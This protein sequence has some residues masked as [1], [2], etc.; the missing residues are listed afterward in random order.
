MASVRDLRNR[1]K[2]IRQTLQI[3]SAM[4]LISTSK[5]RR[6]RKNLEESRPYFDRIR[7][8]M[9]DI[10]HHSENLDDFFFDKRDK[11]KDRKTGIIV[12]TGD[13]GMAGGFYQNVFSTTEK[14]LPALDNP[15]LLMVGNQGTKYFVRKQ[16]PIIE[17]FKSDSDVPSAERVR[18][19]EYFVSSQFR[20][21]MID[22]FHIVYTKMFSSVKT[23]PESIRLLPLE[24]SSLGKKPTGLETE[25]DIVYDYL[26]SPEETFRSL[27][28]QY[29]RGII[30]GALVESYA[31]EQSARM[32]AMDSASK[33]A[34]DMLDKLQLQ[35]N[36]ARQANITAE[37]SEIVS[38][39]AALD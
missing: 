27:V 26:P 12:I 32:M 29:L 33:N 5:L 16:V 6:A 2:G 11:K 36:R 38:G 17:D 21:G 31:S 4:K 19:I 30:F 25:P 37:V 22:E 8:M 18:E 35:F 34:K 7:A 9:D 3:T 24:R 13:R 20:L 14:L 39:A 1:M 23:A 10:S 28:P 15:F